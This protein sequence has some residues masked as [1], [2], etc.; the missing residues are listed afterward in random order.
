[1]NEDGTLN[2]DAPN[3]FNDRRIVIEVIDGVDIYYTA[4]RPMN[5]RG[6]AR[7]QFGQY[8][9][10]T[11]GIH[12]NSEPHK[13]LVQVAPVTVHRDFNKDF[14]RT[15]DALDTGLFGINQHYGEEL[16]IT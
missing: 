3:Q 1:M 5:D 9:A 14:K 10:W 13:A 8:K 4:I 15:G 7:I 16:G 11:V 6:T 2:G 12:G